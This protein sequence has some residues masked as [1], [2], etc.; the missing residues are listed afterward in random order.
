[1]TY[2]IDIDG[3]LVEHGTNELLPGAL[4]LLKQIKDSS[5]RVVFVTRRSNEEFDADPNYSADSAVELLRSI[6]ME[7]APLLYGYGS[8]RVIIDDEEVRVIKH[9]ANDTWSDGEI[10]EAMGKLLPADIRH[11]SL[12][13][14]A[15]V[16]YNARERYFGR[17]EITTWCETCESQRQ[18]WLVVARS[19]AA[20]VGAAVS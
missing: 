6:G 16:G 7:D 15:L 11:H 13:H 8:P 3:T 19:M 10:R 9:W 17:P 12:D 18:E 20:Y 5:G 4:E 2:F 1:M 14:T